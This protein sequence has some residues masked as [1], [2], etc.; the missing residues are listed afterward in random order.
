MNGGVPLSD[1]N[2]INRK[3]NYP[4]EN[5]KCN[6]MVAVFLSKLNKELIVRCVN[7]ATFACTPNAGISKFSFQSGKK[8]RLRL[9]N[10]SAEGIQKFTLDGH[11]LTVIANDFIPINPYSTNLIT[12]G[13]GQRTDVV[14][15]AV[16]QS[17]DAY[18]MRSNLGTLAK[19]CS[20]SSGV[21]PEALAAVCYENADTNSIP[22]SNSSLTDDQ[23]TDCCNDP[24][25]LTTAFCSLTPAPVADTTED[26]SITFGSNGTN[27]VWFMN[28]SSFRGDYNDPLLGAVGRGQGRKFGI[29][30]G[31][32]RP[33]FRNERDNSIDYPEHL[34][35][36]CTSDASSR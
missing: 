15:E 14:V 6:L 12:L 18:W 10:T 28:N 21:S 19:G 2:L 7:L 29:R 9:I 20:G 27:F 32:E 16:G 17:G 1:N 31:M 34:C 11:N 8:Y 33:Q 30:R 4:C 23:L 24:L 25:S 13:V 26:I 3:M 5:S 22:T 35:I 36:F